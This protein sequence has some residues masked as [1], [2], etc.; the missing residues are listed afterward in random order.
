[1]TPNNPVDDG[2]ERL[3]PLRYGSSPASHRH[4]HLVP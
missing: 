4:V 2:P 3:P 1:M